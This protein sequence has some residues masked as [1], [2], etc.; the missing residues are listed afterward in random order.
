[1]SNNIVFINVSQTVAPLPSTLQQTGAFISLGGTNKAA[2]SLTL[3]TSAADLTAIL[4]TPLALTSLAWSSGTVTATA[5]A[6]HGLTNGSVYQLTIAGAIPVGYNGTYAC[7]VTS[8]TAFTYQLASTP[9]TETTPGTWSSAS[10]TELSAMTTTF[11]AQGANTAINVLEL[12]PSTTITGVAA[13]TTWLTNNPGILY[14]VLVPR[15]WDAA[16]S[17]L[18]L[19]QSYESTTS[20]FY[21]FVTT[22]NATFSNYTAL[23]KCVYG[24]IEAPGVVQ[25][26]E[27]SAAADFYQVL[28]QQPSS[29]N[30]IAPLAFRYVFGVTPYPVSG[31]QTLFAAWRAAGI[32][33]TGTGY[34]GGIT[35]S[36]I[37]WGTTAD[38]RPFN[39]WYAVD[40]LQINIDINISNAVINGSNNPINPLYL[41]QDGINRLQAVGA[42]TLA[43]SIT[44]GMLLGTVVQS[45]LDGPTFNAALNAGN[46]AGQ[47]VINAVPFVAYYTA[48]PS[49]FRTGT[50]NGFSITCIP[51]RGFESITININVSDFAA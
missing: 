50:Y 13:L 49:Q 2:N 40:W 7:T 33:W 20:K 11:F 12:G 32:N 36:I 25:A 34:E 37:Y 4:A 41:N 31:N 35:N 17:F 24:K 48:N 43:S 8:T 16:A 38:K 44:F 21:F 51:L 3:L 9:G 45:E 19:L 23:M 27:F 42:G 28:Q 5:S 18:T 47:A 29:T 1:M 39:Y 6:A 26:T 22:T 46:F 14:A 10:N 30:K 15:A